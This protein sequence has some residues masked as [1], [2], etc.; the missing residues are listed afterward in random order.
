MGRVLAESTCGE[1]EYQFDSR[2][3]ENMFGEQVFVFKCAKCGK[4]RL[5]R[6]RDLAPKECAALKT[7]GFPVI[8]EKS[9]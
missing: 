6:G 3:R 9:K 2:R 4:V 8:A 1:H 5:R 7:L